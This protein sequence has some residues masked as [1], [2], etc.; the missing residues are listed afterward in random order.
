MYCC[1]LPTP[2]LIE[3]VEVVIPYIAAQLIH[4]PRFVYI[5][6]YSKVTGADGES[7]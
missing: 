2:A 6:S 3:H 7:Y 5:V 4:G 1:K